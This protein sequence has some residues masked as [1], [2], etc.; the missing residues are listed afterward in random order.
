[1]KRQIFSRQIARNLLF[2]SSGKDK[3]SLY[4]SLNIINH[5]GPAEYL[6]HRPGNQG[7]AKGLGGPFSAFFSLLINDCLGLIKVAFFF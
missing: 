6:N 4:T 7:G 5:I 1:M 3:G 2:I